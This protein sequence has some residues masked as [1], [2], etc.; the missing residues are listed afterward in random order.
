MTVTNWAGNVVFRPDRL[1]RP[2]SVAELQELV[3]ASERARALGS[4]HSFSPVADTTG[5][6]LT[7]ADLPHRVEIDAAAGA[8][9]VSAGSTY[10]EVGATLHEAGFALHNTGSLPH[11]SIAGACATRTHGPRDGNGVLAPPPPPG[12]PV[13]PD[14]GPRPR[15]RGGPG[16]P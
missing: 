14:G 8:V 11:I 15:R 1:H 12:G 13:T 10:G 5:A 2:T 7:V 3:A 4:G 16:L 9:T 6:L